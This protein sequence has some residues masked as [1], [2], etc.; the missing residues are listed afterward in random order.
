[1]VRTKN[2]TD[3]TMVIFS[4]TASIPLAFCLPNNCSAP[5]EIA[6]ERPELFEDCNNTTT[7]NAIETMTNNV[8]NNVCTNDTSYRNYTIYL[9]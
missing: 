9:K 7:I 8:I 3:K 5:P 4:K 2:R 1:M 6:P